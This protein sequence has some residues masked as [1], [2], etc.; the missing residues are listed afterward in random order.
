MP[1]FCRSVSSRMQP[2][3]S[4]WHGPMCDVAALESLNELATAITHEMG[5][6]L[7]PPKSAVIV[8]SRVFLNLHFNGAGKALRPGTTVVV[9]QCD[10][11]VYN[12]RKICAHPEMTRVGLCPFENGFV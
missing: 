3:D 12:H 5:P 7:L 8:W 2:H 11:G 1:S 10:T 4:L 9:C 6:V